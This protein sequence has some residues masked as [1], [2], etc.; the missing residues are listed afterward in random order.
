MLEDGRDIFS[1]KS[2]HDDFARNN[3]LNMPGNADGS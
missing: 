2:Y 3:N 1:V